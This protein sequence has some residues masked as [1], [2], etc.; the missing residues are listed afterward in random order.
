MDTLIFEKFR[1]ECMEKLRRVID[2]I[3]SLGKEENLGAIGFIT[4][5]DFYGFYVTWDFGDNVDFEEYYDWENGIN[6]DF[7]YQPLVDIVDGCKEID[8]CN[9][10]EEKWDFAVTLLAT[11]GEIIKQLPEDIFLKNNFK[12]ENILFF[13]TMDSGDYMQEMLDV[14]IKKF[15]AKETLELFESL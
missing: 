11:L 10:S 1:R 15:N 3:L 9:P 13:S 12:K 5:D 4:T 2:E 8:F 14:S 7:L 6:P